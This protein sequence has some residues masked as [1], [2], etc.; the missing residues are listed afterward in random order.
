MHTSGLLLMD[1][2][3]IATMIKNN[4]DHDL[5]KYPGM[6][7]LAFL[8][9]LIA[10]LTL[11]GLACSLFSGSGDSTPSE[12]STHLVEMTVIPTTVQGEA[13]AIPTRTSGPL[14]GIAFV[15]QARNIPG[16][17]EDI[18]MIEPDGSNPRNLT[19]SRGDD[20]E[21]AW[22]PD[23]TKLAFTSNRDGNWEIYV[24]NA[25]G[26]GQ[27][28]LTDH[29][30]HDGEPSWSPDG[31]SLVFSS[32]REG[33]YDLYIFTLKDNELVRLTD[34]PAQENYPD[35]SPDGSRIVFS[36]FG[37]ERDA[38]IY[39][40]DVDQSNI[41]YL[42]WGP[43][44][45]P[46]WSPDG[47]KIAFDGEP[48][49]SKFEIYVMN[50]DGSDMVRLTEHPMGAGAYNKKPS[51][52]PDGT[53]IVFHSSGRDLTEPVNDLFIINADGS[54]ETQITNSKSTDLYYGASMPDWSPVH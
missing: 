41:T 46:T 35:W 50:S 47:N 54:V 33:G 42:T 32:N 43:L 13:S 12:E 28:R 27:T 30:E 6:K 3:W 49:D 11:S 37:G 40:I 38:G 29:P 15:A 44:H 36:S 16:A 48:S 17:G 51:W 7:A 45:Y 22:S 21:P 20:R 52:S 25:D 9:L 5:P 14:S 8:L 23:G 19:Q 31:G 24:M 4:V 26:S 2:G 10:S 53:Q 1:K 39:T 18:F 34:H